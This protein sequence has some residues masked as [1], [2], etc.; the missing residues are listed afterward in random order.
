[1][2]AE[3]ITLLRHLY[4]MYKNNSMPVSRYYVLISV[5]FLMTFFF[6]I[7]LGLSRVPVF[8]LV[9]C[10]IVIVYEIVSPYIYTAR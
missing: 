1:M 6:D 8:T 5:S 7:I 9:L 2:Y 3:P 10:G 4:F